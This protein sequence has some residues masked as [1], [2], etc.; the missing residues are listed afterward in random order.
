ML[1]KRERGIYLKWMQQLQM[2]KT[3][4]PGQCDPQDIMIG[5]VEEQTKVMAKA[6]KPGEG[7]A[8]HPVA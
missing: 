2:A 5:G 4:N 3:R 6:E 8:K 1:T 7:E